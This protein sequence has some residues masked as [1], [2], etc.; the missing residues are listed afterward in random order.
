M[1]IVLNYIT[2]IIAVFLRKVIIEAKLK[3]S[4]DFITNSKNKG[5]AIW[6]VGLVKRETGK[7]PNSSDNIELLNN[8]QIIK[9]PREVAEIFKKY[10]ANESKLEYYSN[11]Q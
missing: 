2:K 9:T 3:W 6:D 1:I 7:T 8:G 5:K 10:F 11:I 4:R